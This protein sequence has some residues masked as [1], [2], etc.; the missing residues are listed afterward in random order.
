[1]LYIRRDISSLQKIIMKIAIIGRTEVLFDT[2]KHLSKS[3]K[4]SCIIT[5]RAS[6]H[7]QKKERDFKLLAKKLQCPFMLAASIDTSVVSLITQLHPD[8][9]ISVNWI[10]LFQEN[11]IK[12][13]YYGILNCHPGDLPRYRGNAATNWAILQREKTTVFTVY[14]VVANKLDSGIILSNKKIDITNKMTIADINVLWK[15]NA[16]ILFS[17]AINK[18]RTDNI[19]PYRSRLIQAGFRCYPRIPEDSKIDWSDS[20]ENIHNLIR[21]SSKPYSGAYTY[22][23]IKNRIKKLYI[24]KSSVVE[25]VTNDISTP[26]HIIFNNSITG[27]SYIYCGQGII[28]LHDVQYEG[29]QNFKPGRVWK[30]IRMKF[31]IDWENEIIKLYKALHK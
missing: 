15:Q 11:F 14:S 22:L 4:I 6:S 18:L 20:A 8:I 27:E 26:G 19:L 17:K 25:Q 5:A 31:G 13:F 10:S 21:A 16:P 1:M 3:H 7:Y 29:G 23:K 9:A 30:S 12:Q 2:V 24:W 28:S